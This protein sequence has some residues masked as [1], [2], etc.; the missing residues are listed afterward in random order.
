[1]PSGS[2]RFL[3]HMSIHVW[4]TEGVRW[5]DMPKDPAFLVQ[6]QTFL[7]SPFLLRSNTALFD[8]TLRQLQQ[9]KMYGYTLS[10]P[11]HMH[12]LRVHPASPNPSSPA[13]FCHDC[14]T[15]CKQSTYS[16]SA[17]PTSPGTTLSPRR[18]M[19]C[20]TSPRKTRPD[21]NGATC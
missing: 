16:V 7:V 11:P 4:G 3:R 9:M 18:I 19:P 12:D 20:P 2:T 17:R 8:L 10:Q 1:M 13:A 6:L 5:Q 21:R 15:L 14:T